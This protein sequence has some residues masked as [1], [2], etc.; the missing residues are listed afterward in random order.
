[1]GS[2]LAVNQLAAHLPPVS[3]QFSPFWSS[4]DR[5][6]KLH[7]EKFA[8]IAQQIED[9]ASQGNI[10]S[11]PCIELFKTA[12]RHGLKKQWSAQSKPSIGKTPNWI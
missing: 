9:I 12:F 7:N 10:L 1:M 6:E 3:E 8:Q 11:S 2:L 5:I 4:I